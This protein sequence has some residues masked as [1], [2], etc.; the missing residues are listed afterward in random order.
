MSVLRFTT[1]RKSLIKEPMFDP[2]PAEVAAINEG[3]ACREESSAEDF[4]AWL[5]ALPLPGQGPAHGKARDR[6][7][8]T[9]DAL[10]ERLAA[11]PLIGT[12]ARRIRPHVRRFQLSITGFLVFYQV[13]ER[14]RRVTILN[15]L[16][17]PTMRY[18]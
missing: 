11:F 1:K 4:L 18:R 17:G 8:S 5:R 7:R 13:A 6:K 16:P 9:L 10:V 3:L 12:R 14:A 15:I 2:T